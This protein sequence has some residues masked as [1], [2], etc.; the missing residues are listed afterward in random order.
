MKKI[1]IIFA[2]CANAFTLLLQAD[3]ASTESPSLVVFNRVRYL[4]F[5]GYEKDMLG[6]KFLASNLSATDGFQELGEIKELPAN[7]QWGE[8]TFTNTQPYRWIK[9]LAPPGTYGRVSK[10]EFYADEKRLKVEMISWIYGTGFEHSF[11]SGYDHAGWNGTVAYDQLGADPYQGSHKSDRP[12]NQYVV[13][14]LGDDATGPSPYFDPGETESKTPIE[15]AIKSK[16]PGAVIRYTLDGTIPT[17]VNG[18]IYNEPLT[19]NKTTTIVAS[20]FVEGLA[21]TREVC[22]TYI[23]G[24]PLHHQTF[25]LGNSLTSI[26]QGFDLQARTAGSIHH[27]SRYLSGGSWTKGLWNMVMVDVGDP[28]DK[29]GWQ[30]LY[31]SYIM[32][33]PGPYPLSKVEQARNSWSKLW[34]KVTEIDDLTFQPRDFDIA[35]EAD[36]E[37]RFLNL[38]EQKSPD[39]QPWL[40]IEWVE[41]GRNL[42]PT[43]LGQEPTSEMKTV[44]P[45]L[46]WEESMA[47]MILYGED[48]KRKVDETYKGIKLLRIIPVALAMGW[49]HHMIEQ[50][51][52]PGFAKD[53]FY[54]K[55]FDDAVHTNKEGGYLVDCMFYSSFYGE[56]P[57][58]KFLP[59]LTTL[60]AEQARIIQRL[61]WDTVKNYP[62][63]G[64]YEEGTVP[65]DAPEFSPAAEPINQV[66]QVSLSSS[67]AGAWFRYTLDGTPPTRTNGYVYCGVISARPGMTIK[68]IAYKSGMADSPVTEITYPNGSSLAP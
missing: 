16:T 20:A 48:L 24:D 55:L 37:N 2:I 9:Y 41:R 43:D 27:S 50:G 3:D 5:K 67:T 8:L 33:Q 66:T 44:Y 51:E 13:I 61:A 10:I 7:G 11:I 68:A 34:P 52:V 65:V 21:P 31:G 42:R 6:G 38:A 59:V 18:Q 54:P 57:E 35:E 60:T 63:S 30:N 62:D 22:A 26:T 12:D 32:G 4:P 17:E 14:D 15:V 53:D 56:S 47:A 23:I 39:L 25:H 29:D 49:M 45:A 58:G 64:Y 40:Y 46:T 19:I 1:F 28:N 36:Y